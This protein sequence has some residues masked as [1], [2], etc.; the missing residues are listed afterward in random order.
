M[1]FSELQQQIFQQIKTK[2]PPE[3]PL[4]ETIAEVLEVSTDSAYRRIRG[5]KTMSLEE[6]Y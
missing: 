3:A 2:L 5:E 1:N 4:V 6:T